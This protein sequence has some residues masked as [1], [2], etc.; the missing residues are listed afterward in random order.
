MPKRKNILKEVKVRIKVRDGKEGLPLA[1][2]TVED[3]EAVV[4]DTSIRAINE[5]LDGLHKNL[6]NDNIRY[7]VDANKIRNF[8]T[9]NVVLATDETVV[10]HSL[11]VRPY[12]YRVIMK[13]SSAW[14]QTREPDSKNIYLAATGAVTVDILV[15]G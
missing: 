3:L 12:D 15:E 13:G 14:W 2:L 9:N 7:G 6:S 10:P 1:K 8:R 5:D 4:D 11:G